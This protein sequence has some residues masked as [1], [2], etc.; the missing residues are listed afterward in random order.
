MG[1]YN[2]E[3]KIYYGPLDSDHR[4]VPAPMITISKEN[5]YSNDSIIGYTYTI[6]L[7]GSATGFDLR[8]VSGEYDMNNYQYAFA[9]VLDH[10][11]KIRKILSQNGNILNIVNA[12]DESILKAKGGI[13]RSFNFDES[14]NNWRHYANYTATIEFSAIEFIG[15]DWQTFTPEDCT[16]LHLSSDSYPSDNTGILDISQFKVKTFDDSWSITFDENDAFNRVK[17]NDVGQNLNIDNNS[18]TI[19]YNISA[20]GK[21]YFVYDDEEANTSKLLPA[22]EQAKNFVQYRLWNQVT[23]LINGVLKNTATSS[24]TPTDTFDTAHVPG[25]SDQGLM[26][27]IGN[28]KY[29]IYNETITCETSESDGSFSATYSAIVKNNKTTDFSG[30]D[31]KHTVSKTMSVTNSASNSIYSITVTGSI[32]GLIEGGIIRSSKPIE[33]PETGSILIYNGGSNT[34]YSNAKL[35]LDKIYSE[36][37]YNGGFGISGKKDLKKIY[38]DKLGITTS[39]L[40]FSPNIDD[41]VADPPH[42]TSFNLTHD[43]NTGTITYSAEYSSNNACGRSYQQVSVQTSFPNKVIATFNIPKSNSCPFIQELGTYT[44]KTVSVTVE[45][46][47]FSSNGKPRPINLMNEI[48]CG[49]C[50][51]EQYL[52]VSLPVVNGILTQ[53]QYTKNPIDGSYTLNL[54]YICDNIGCNI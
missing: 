43:Y 19:Q 33:L 21:H 48:L 31:A 8:D 9:S 12:D 5:T 54:N 47:D 51:A 32:E 44:I 4:L 1:N 35:I 41:P 7:N 24:C 15:A 46:K 38:K 28:S 13:L 14:D 25:I 17:L 42:P 37:D 49:N 45:G 40:G 18:F 30:P 34:K 23:N 27:D 36:F 16:N 39:A 22:W 20:T 53:K 10:I 50:L 3:V 6:T 52:P 11:Y 2:P 29:K 26:K